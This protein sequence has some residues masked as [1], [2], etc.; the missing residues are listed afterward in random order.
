MRRTR[1]EKLSGL[2]ELKRLKEQAQKEI[3]V[4]GDTG[5]KIT[6]GMGTCGIAAGAREVMHAVL[7]ELAARDIEANV[8]TVGCVGVCSQ[9][10]LLDVEQ[11]GAP[12][13]T[14]GKVTPG[15]VPTI[16]EEHL[17]KGKVVRQWVVAKETA[18]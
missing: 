16:I 11:A 6:I 1:M 9:E 12:K 3:R 13:V 2:E 14:Y 7:R 17:V 18:Q 5:T 15:M 8:A 10:P 4:R